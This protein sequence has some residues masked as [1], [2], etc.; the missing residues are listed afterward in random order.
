MIIFLRYYYRS[1]PDA[2][3]AAREA[4]STRAYT[5]SFVFCFFVVFF[6]F[7]CCC[8][9]CCFFFFFVFL[10]LFFFCFVFFLFLFFFCFF[11]GFFFC[12][13]FVCF[14]VFLFFFVC[15][16]FFFFFCL[17][18]FFQWQTVHSNAMYQIIDCSV[19]VF[20]IFFFFFF[21]FF[22]L[23]DFV[24]QNKPL[25]PAEKKNS[26]YLGSPEIEFKVVSLTDSY[27]RGVPLQE[28]NECHH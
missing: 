18:F 21:F 24:L 7:F 26:N 1:A 28:S 6:C 5:T 14:F 23:Y 27:S 15:F 4:I 3:Y 17:F 13:F 10:L 16:F 11:G 2:I 12:V 22:H 19:T 20:V 25:T 8:C 9:C